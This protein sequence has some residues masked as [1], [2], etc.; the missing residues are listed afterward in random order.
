ME[1]V[2]VT[3]FGHWKW[4]A[5]KDRDGYG[6]FLMNGKAHKAHRVAWLLFRD[7]PVP[8]E[9]D[10][11]CRRRDCVNPNHLEAVSHL[12]NVRRGREATK[13][14]CKQGHEF[15]PQNTRLDKHGIRTC[16]TCDN[17]WSREW[18]ARNPGHDKRLREE[19]R[20]G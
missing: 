15:T 16:R 9:I 6:R 17:R 19:R 1:K 7:E 11:L 13:T 8:H 18:R 20:V 14:R 4:T 2:R 3:Y 10:H 5:S 12:E